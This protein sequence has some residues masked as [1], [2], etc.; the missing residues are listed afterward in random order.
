MVLLGLKSKPRL[1]NVS[2]DHRTSE[3]MEGTR[4]DVLHGDYGCFSVPRASLGGTGFVVALSLRA[5]LPEFSSQGGAAALSCCP[6]ADRSGSCVL[7]PECPVTCLLLAC[8]L[9]IKGGPGKRGRLSLAIHG[10]SVCVRVCAH[11]RGPSLM[12]IF[13]NPLSVTGL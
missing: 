3:L 8:A 10:V 4:R 1:L 7:R 12:I 2:P 9:A 11:V 5:A 6:S 13:E